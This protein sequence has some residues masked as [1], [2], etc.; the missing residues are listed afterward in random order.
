MTPRIFDGHNDTLLN[1]YLQDRGQGRSFFERSEVGHIDLPRALEGQFGGGLFA[2]FVPNPT[3]KNPPAGP[4]DWSKLP[5]PIAYERAVEFAEG[6]AGILDEIVAQS[7][8]QLVQVRSVDDIESAWEAGQLAAS[9]H[10]EGAE[11][12]A[13]EDDF[14]S[15]HRWYAR[16][17][18]SI[19][20]V[21]SRAN[22]YATGIPFVFPTDPD[23]GPGLTDLGKALIAECNALGILIDLSH[24]NAAGFWDIAKL[25]DAPLV[26][27]HSNVHAL[28]PS[29]RNLTADQLQAIRESDGLVGLNFGV[30]FLRADGDWNEDAS[31]DEARQHLDALIEALGEDRVGFGSDFDGAKVPSAI[32][33]A[34]GLPVFIDH[35]RQ[36][37]Y[38]TPL[39]EK[40][41]S[42]NWMRVLRLTWGQ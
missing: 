5:E 17:L 35:L 37:G 4:P 3:P 2:V 30:G 26:A 39:L 13:T 41:C 34:A 19:G 28:C 7:D 23:I 8:G 38:D 20:P 21:W 18:R 11:P 36:H 6:M 14:E 25:S 16:G 15:L 29:G 40:I 10:F 27:T 32:G 33:D 42:G 9:F 24:I 1:L 22:A 31:L 12:I